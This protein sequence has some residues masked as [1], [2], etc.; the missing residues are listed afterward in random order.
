MKLIG[1]PD[2]PGLRREKWHGEIR[3]GNFPGR[4]SGLRGR[5]ALG[6]HRGFYRD[7]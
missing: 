5:A 1:L 3:A 6:Q 4:G 2:E 7:P